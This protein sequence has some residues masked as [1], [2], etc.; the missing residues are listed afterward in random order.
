M[1]GRT[2]GNSFLYKAWHRDNPHGAGLPASRLTCRSMWKET[3]DRTI[4]SASKISAPEVSGTVERER[5]FRLLDRGRGK[6]VIWVAAPAGSGKTTLVSGWLHHRKVAFIWYQV[7]AGDGDPA[8]FFMYFGLAARMAVP[9]RPKPLPL[10]TPEYLMGIPVF[11]RRFFEDVCSRLPASAA[12][13]LDNYQDAPPGSLLHTILRHGIEAARPGITFVVV[14][15]HDSPPQLSRLRVANQLFYIGWSDLRFSQEESQMMALSHGCGAID[16][17]ALVR[18]HRRTD[19]WAA[20]L[21]LLLRARDQWQVSGPSSETHAILFDYFAEEIFSQTKGP[22]RDF[23]LK[24]SFLPSM[25]VCMAERITGNEDA[26]VILNQLCR[27]HYF[28]ESYPGNE[29]AYRY[30]P[31]FHEFLRNG[32]VTCYSREET[33]RIQLRAA[34]L[35]VECGHFDY[36]GDI[37]CDAGE[38]EGLI[39]LILDHAQTMV[40]QGRLMPLDRWLSS[41]PRERLWREPWLCYWSGVC[42]HPFD[43]SASERFFGEAFRLFREKN[44]P[45]EALLAWAGTVACIITEWMDFSKLD[46]WIDWLSEEVD[47]TLDAMP[48]ELRARIAGLMLICLTFRQPQHPKIQFY[49]EKAA[50]LLDEPLE[51][52]SLLTISGH[53]MTHYTKMGLLVKARVV[54]DL[55]K[56]RILRKKDMA[57][58]EYILWRTVTTSYFALSGVKVECLRE[59]RNGL[60]LAARSGM[61][62]Y[63]I[64]ILFFGAM[65][66]FIDSD[67]TVID[68]YLERISGVRRNHGLILPIISRQI[69]GWKC[70]LEEDYARAREHVEAAM[71]QTLRLGSAIE[72]AINRICCSL[73]LF[74]Q[75]RREEARNL[76]I[77]FE[78]PENSVYISYMRLTTEAYFSFRCED[79]ISG[80]RLLREAMAIGSR[81]RI[82][83]HHYWSLKTTRYLCGKA[84]ELGI[85]V[86][87]VR[88]LA[89]L[90][91]ISLAPADRM[92]FDLATPVAI[93]TLGRFDILIDGEPVA[94]GRKVKKKALDLLKFLISSGSPDV[95]KETVWDALWPEVEG[96]RANS[97]FKFTLHQLRQLLK[98]ETALILRNG[99]LSFNP[100][101]CR[102]D[103]LVLMEVSGKVIE[104]CRKKNS[105]PSESGTVN[106]GDLA[107]RAI[108]LYGGD[109]LGSDVDLL[110][111]APARRRIRERMLWMLH[112]TGERMRSLNLW[113]EALFFH[114]KS[115]EIDDT[116]EEAYRCIMR[117]HAALGRTDLVTDTF[118][119]CRRAISREFA[120]PPSPE[121]D[122]VY[123][124]LVEK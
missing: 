118:L 97:S 57:S 70:M 91:R 3:M 115:L 84:L 96:D 77:S 74:E 35:L 102:V 101:Y 2:L 83:M 113:E 39:N 43:L 69:N 63:D 15:R 4:A 25:T 99:Q 50:A 22:I 32:A 68:E 106:V 120:V 20:G 36:A 14:S 26:R 114:E 27:E 24:T 79:E 16:D 45:F 49:E 112:L 88:E 81:H 119:R 75:D 55:V 8:T 12:I 123:R 100:S 82:M 46:P 80:E 51:L 6:P 23:L 17:D 110:W 48:P 109:F 33:T 9:K 59:N 44:H 13:V 111:T 72:H 18:L 28:I 47:K 29:V 89:S 85:E 38:H 42:S 78:Y 92:L 93:H 41:I 105:A 19:G 107:R 60:A 124:S 31:L 64:F 10:L 58:P 104:L 86:A 73:V 62:I 98:S 76:L 90:H 117:C 30:H 121:T 40:D 87:Y 122:A 7:D 95:A 56:P 1:A 103:A 11:T 5:L 52:A 37:L 65:A 21:A 66:G 116:R 61:H 71:Q 94:F 67:L 34:K 54:L 53:L 108:A